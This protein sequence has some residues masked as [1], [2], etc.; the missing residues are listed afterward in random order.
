MYP[1]D[2][3]SKI[4]D[5][6]LRTI[7]AQED[8]VLEGGCEDLVEYTAAVRLRRSLYLVLQRLD[9]LAGIE[10]EDE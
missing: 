1:T 2:L 6:L 4:R 9:E 5:F 3:Y 7:R 8:V 10:D